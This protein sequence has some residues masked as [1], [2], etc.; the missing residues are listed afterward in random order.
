MR[1][2]H[3]G[4]Y[5]GTTRGGPSKISRYRYPTAGDT[6][7]PG[8]RSSTASTSRSPSR[9]SASSV[10]SGHAVPHVVFAGD[11]NHLVGFT[12][13][14]TS[15]NPYLE[16]FGEARPVAG[17]VLPA[18]G[19]YEIVFD[20]RSASRAGPFTFRYWVNDTKPPSLRVAL[21]A[22]AAR[23]RSRSPTPARAS[24]RSR[25]GPRS[26][27]AASP[28]ATPTGKLVLRAAPGHAHLVIVTASDYQELKNM[29]DVVADQA[30]HGDAQAHRRR[31]LRR[32]R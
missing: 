29:E 9:T 21:D 25:S 4:I 15:L 18:P 20:T 14:P 7:Y 22:P 10:L 2:T 1:L 27:A 13:L 5:D 26:T 11:E 6:L 16:S 30:E 24:I 3:P 23:S 17:A 32:G 28:S 31:A 8:P 19:N 12:G